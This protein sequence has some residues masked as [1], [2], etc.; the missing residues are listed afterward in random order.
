[1]RPPH[2]PYRGLW[3]LGWLGALLA[4]AVWPGFRP[5]L[6]RTLE[7]QVAQQTHDQYRL[8]SSSLRACLLP[9]AMHL[10]GLV[11]G[12]LHLRVGALARQPAPHPGPHSTSRGRR[13]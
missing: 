1:M 6:R 11:L 2:W 8:T 4:L 10:R 9:Q 5:W 13:G 3:G 12:S 7:K